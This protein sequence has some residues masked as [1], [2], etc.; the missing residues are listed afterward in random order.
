ML[1]HSLQ[2]YEAVQDIADFAFQPD[3]DNQAT[4]LRTEPVGTD[5]LGRQYFW[6]VYLS[7]CTMGWC[8][9]IRPGRLCIHYAAHTHACIN[10]LYVLWYIKHESEFVEELSQLSVYD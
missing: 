9:C 3:A 6:C 5:R 10:N 1:A 8:T 4:M 7:V 2:A